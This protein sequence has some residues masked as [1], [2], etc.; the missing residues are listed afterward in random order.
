MRYETSIVYELRFPKVQS[1]EKIA[2]GNFCPDTSRR[3]TFR[4]NTTM[5]CYY[6]IIMF[7]FVYQT[8]HLRFCSRVNRFQLFSINTT[9]SCYGHVFVCYI[10]LSDTRHVTKPV[11]YH[12][13]RDSLSN[14][15]PTSGDI[16]QRVFRF[17]TSL[18]PGETL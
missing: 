2:I 15:E 7:S 6:Y 17:G 9:M 8:A 4:I 3:V 14:K 16:K 11:M 18:A 12:E 5:S 10:N 13:K 1:F